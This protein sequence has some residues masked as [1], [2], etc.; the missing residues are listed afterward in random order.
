MQSHPWPLIKTRARTF[1]CTDP[2]NPSGKIKRLSD[3]QF[4][5][6]G[7]RLADVAGRPLWNELL[8]SVAVVG[9]GARGLDISAGQNRKR[10][11]LTI[12]MHWL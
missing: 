4:P 3:G 2:L 10:H 6:V 11:L 8:K 5:Y 9:N 1:T 12:W 7:V